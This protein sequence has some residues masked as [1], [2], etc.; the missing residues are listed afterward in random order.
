MSESGQKRKGSQR[1][2]VVRFNTHKQTSTNATSMSAYAKTGCEQTQQGSPYSITSPARPNSVSAA[3]AAICA[4]IDGVASPVGTKCRDLSR[5]RL[6]PF[7]PSVARD[8]WGG[9]CA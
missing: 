3:G 2:N 7:P 8:T 6:Q 1:A 4:I 5:L 9:R